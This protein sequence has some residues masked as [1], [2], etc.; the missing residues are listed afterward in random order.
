MCRKCSAGHLT[1]WESSTLRYALI[2]PWWEMG[3][4]H[5]PYL[6]FQLKYL[7][8]CDLEFTF[9]WPG[10]TLHCS[11]LGFPGGTSGK[12]PACQCSRYKRLRFNPWVRKI[13]LEEGMTTHPFSYLE[14]PTDIGALHVTVHRVAKSWTQLKWFS[15]HAHS[16]LP[17]WAMS[18]S[19]QAPCS[20]WARSG[21][22]SLQGWSCWP[23]MLTPEQS[24]HGGPQAHKDPTFALRCCLPLLSPPYPLSLHCRKPC[25]LPTYPPFSFLALPLQLL[26]SSALFLGR[27]SP[28][29]HDLHLACFV[30]P[31]CSVMPCRRCHLHLFQ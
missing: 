31:A 1:R 5:L 18:P 30:Y 2:H 16:S 27:A 15:P 29:S 24:S 21:P 8:P 10:N 11:S 26:T 20:W 17:S 23:V 13:P 22:S 3:P 14:N 7:D 12:E 19:K 6:W 9:R 25:F 28:C 4:A